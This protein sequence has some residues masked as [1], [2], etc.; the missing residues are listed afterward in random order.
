MRDTYIERINQFVVEY[1]EDFPA[2]HKAEMR[3]NGIDPDNYWQLKWSFTTEEAANEQC[4]HE[5]EWYANFCA[6][7]GYAIRK[8]FR[9]RDLGAPVEIERSVMF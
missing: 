2:E 4:R 1:L 9:V 8:Q 5:V 3:L 6:E 7:R